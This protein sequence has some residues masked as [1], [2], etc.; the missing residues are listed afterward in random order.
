MWE[1]SGKKQFNGLSFILAP[2][3]IF[4]S[5][6]K[7]YYCIIFISLFPNLLNKLVSPIFRETKKAANSIRWFSYWRR[8]Y[9]HGKLE[10]LNLL[11]YYP[12]KKMGPPSPP[13]KRFNTERMPMRDQGHMDDLT[14][15]GR[16][17][18]RLQGMTIRPGPGTGELC[19]EGWQPLWKRLRVS[20]L[21][22]GRLET[23]GRHLPLG[24]GAGWK[25]ES[26][27]VRRC[28][29]LHYWTYQGSVMKNNIIV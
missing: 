27:S 20:W 9:K 4:L 2:L 5:V 8:F 14:W 12:P 16:R 6:T 23:F 3:D 18:A 11:V 13:G 10:T 28:G 25:G 17:G 22:I 26:R 15:H 21:G 29:I 24:Q 19:R 1:S 7:W